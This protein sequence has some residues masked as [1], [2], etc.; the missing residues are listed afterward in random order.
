MYQWTEHVSINKAICVLKV[1]KDWHCTMQMPFKAHNSICIWENEWVSEWASRRE[2]AWGTER[3]RKRESM[4]N[5]VP[6]VNRYPLLFQGYD[7]KK[8]HCNCVW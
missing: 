5:K 7:S 3:G 1:Y 2:I 4:S 6:S 8:L